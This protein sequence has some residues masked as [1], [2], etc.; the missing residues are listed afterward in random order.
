M[1]TP[2]LGQAEEIFSSLK[3]EMSLYEAICTATPNFK[4]L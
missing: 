2:K 4:M 1:T 3:K